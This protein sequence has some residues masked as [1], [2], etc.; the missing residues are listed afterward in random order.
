[1]L[2]K[3]WSA[4]TLGIEAVRIVIE[5]DVVLGNPRFTI[6][7]LPDLAVREAWARVRAA[8][9]NCGYRLPPRDVTVSLSPA[10]VKKEGSSF[11]LPIAIGILQAAE[12]LTEAQ[13]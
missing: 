1:M 7:G 10:D 12:V 11:D 13:L 6:V 2:A 9:Y 5:V 3:V 8:L 4:A